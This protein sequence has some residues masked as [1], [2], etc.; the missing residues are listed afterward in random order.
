MIKLLENYNVLSNGAVFKYL[1]LVP[2]SVVLTGA[3]RIK[4][5]NWKG[6]LKHSFLYRK[7]RLEDDQIYVLAHNSFS[8]YYHWLL[9][10]LPRLLEAQ[11]Q[12]DNFILLLP[13]SYTNS[14]YGETLTLLG[15]HHVYRM[16][17]KIKYLVP[18]LALPYLA[19]AMG[20]HSSSTLQE[21]KNSI[22]SV[23]ATKPSKARRLY[24]SRRKAT[25]RKVSNER[26]VE[27]LL[28]NYGFKVVYFEDYTFQ[29]VVQLCAGAELL[30]G[31]HGA[32]LANILFMPES[33]VIVEFRKF[34]NGKNV[35]FEYLADA[36][37]LRF[38]LLYCHAVDESQ[39]VQDADLYVDV[40]AL[41]SILS[42]YIL[43]PTRK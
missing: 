22:L 40:K 25:R 31:I 9:E 1:T 5:Y 21:L 7:L 43:Q 12:L 11:K 36:L 26:E 28:I 6:L 42:Q 41:K 39:S 33:A 29:E 2:E 13:D 10:S 32:G 18:K 8:G 14:F 15:I 24:V 38:Q 23:V 3:G 20:Y 35:F 30:V 27:R 16:Q 4:L 37:K 17:P 34:D 19:E